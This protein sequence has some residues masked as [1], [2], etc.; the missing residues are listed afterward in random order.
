MVLADEGNDKLVVDLNGNVGIGTTSP[1]FTNTSFKG[2]EV[3]VSGDLFPNVRLERVSGSSKT[4]QAYE[5]VIGSGGNWHVRNAT[6]GTAPLSIATND[7]ITMSG[8]LASGAITSTGLNSTSGT[9]QYADGGSAF[10]SSD[11]DGYPRFTVTNGSAQIGLF[12]SGSSAGGSY[13]GADSSKLLRVYNSSFASKFDIAIPI[14]FL[15]F[16]ISKVITFFF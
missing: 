16:S 2:L 1:V 8:T 4:N 13:I 9:V 5:M 7:A 10:D 3:Q 14:T 15:N 12:R 11:A 6:T